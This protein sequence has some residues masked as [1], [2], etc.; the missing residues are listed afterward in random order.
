MLLF[1]CV[2]AQDKITTLLSV[3]SFR[4]HEWSRIKENKTK[5]EKVRQTELSCLSKIRIK[6]ASFSHVQFQEASLLEVYIFGPCYKSGQKK[7]INRYLVWEPLNVISFLT[8]SNIQVYESL[9]RDDWLKQKEYYL[10]LIIGETRTHTRA[11]KS[12][13][14]TIELNLWNT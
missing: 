5:Q 2:S 8:F 7:E 9:L 3:I 11:W 13:M 12:C 6:N 4:I 14:F 10:L 1:I